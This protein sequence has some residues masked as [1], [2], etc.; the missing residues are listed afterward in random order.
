MAMHH[1]EESALVH[2]APKKLFAFVD[3]PLHLSSHMGRPSWM[4]GGGRMKTET[5]KGRGQKVGSHIR[6]G[7]KI[8]GIRLFLDEVVTQY[9]PPRVKTWETVG[10]LRLLIIGHYQMSV[11]V[12][13]HEGGSV[14]RVSIDYGLPSTNVWLGRLFGRTY[15]KW[16]V[17]QM[18]KSAYEHFEKQKR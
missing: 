15:A 6:M 16:C 2:A 3:D 18:I 8:F 10:N 12:E 5:D 7:G 4:M 9:N 11:K 17:S 1:Y 13:P 14:L